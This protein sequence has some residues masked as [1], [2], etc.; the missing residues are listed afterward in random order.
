MP[1][2]YADGT[3]LISLLSA[4]LGSKP[5]GTPAPGGYDVTTY[6]WGQVRA[7]TFHDGSAAVWVEA[8]SLA[9]VRFEG[10]EGVEVGWTREQALAAGAQNL[11]D[12]NGDGKADQLSIGA[13]EVAGTKSLEDPSRTGREYVM[14]VMKGDTVALI[15]SNGNDFSDL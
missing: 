12:E 6:D 8:P 9:G 10:P 15:I 2:S 1:T 13:R 5:S 3:A 4:A 14:L 7:S 11:Y